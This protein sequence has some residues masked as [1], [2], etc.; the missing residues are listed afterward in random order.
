MQDDYWFKKRFESLESQVFQV[1]I[2]LIV[3]IAMYLLDYYSLLGFSIKV[4]F[5][6]AV[7][8]FVVYMIIKFIEFVFI[9]PKK[10]K[11]DKKLQEIIDTNRIKQEKENE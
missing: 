3:L 11:A 6:L 10:R 5:W 9:A 8:L 4:V 2:M 7:F 1:K